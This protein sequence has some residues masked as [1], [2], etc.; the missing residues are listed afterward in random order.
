MNGRQ[1]G[2]CGVHEAHETPLRMSLVNL[3]RE[4]REDGYVH[5]G[6]DYSHELRCVDR[7]A[8]RARARKAREE[9]R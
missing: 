7:V 9:A 1:C 4:A 2:R 3:E 6:S 5:A 8:C